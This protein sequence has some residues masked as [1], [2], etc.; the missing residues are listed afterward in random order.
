VFAHPCLTGCAPQQPHHVTCAVC[1]AALPPSGH[2]ALLIPG[3][4]GS[5]E[6]VCACAG[7]GGAAAAAAAAASSTKP[8]LGGQASQGP[9]TKRPCHTK[10]PYMQVLMH[11]VAYTYERQASIIFSAWQAVQ[12]AHGLRALSVAAVCCCRSGH[13]PVRLR[14]S[15]QGPGMPCQQTAAAAALCQRLTGE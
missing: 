8:W 12:T 10:V 15:L 1:L 4:A 6:Q 9:H 14:G 3:N 5:Y 11:H 2:P 7:G 13:W